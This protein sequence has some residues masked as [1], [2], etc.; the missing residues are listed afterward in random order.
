MIGFGEQAEVAVDFRDGLSAMSLLRSLLEPQK[1]RLLSMSF[2]VFDRKKP[3]AFFQATAH[4]KK[5]IHHGRVTQ[6]ANLQVESD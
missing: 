2:H 1:K 4:G 5:T 6:G 3:M